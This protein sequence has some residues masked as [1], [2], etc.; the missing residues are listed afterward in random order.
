[1]LRPGPTDDAKVRSSGHPVGSAIG[2]DVRDLITDTAQSSRHARHRLFAATAIITCAIGASILLSA[3]APAYAT[4][5]E[6]LSIE[7][8]SARSARVVVGVVTAVREDAGTPATGA[9]TAVDIAVSDML[10]GAGAGT[11]TVY[12]AGGVEPGGVR[13]FVDGMASFVVGEP[14]AV[15]ADADGWIMGGYQGKVVVRGSSVPGQ[16]ESVAAFSARVRGAAKGGAVGLAVA[17][18]ESAA[19]PQLSPSG[20][21]L[22]TSAS[23]PVITSISPRSA[24]AGT[25]TSIT[26]YGSGFGSGTGSVSF[27][28]RDSQRIGASA[29]SSWTDTR[30]VCQV[31]TASIGGY[32]ASAGS[33]AVLVTTLGGLTSTPATTGAADLAV[34]FG[35]GGARW[36]AKY[37]GAPHTRVTFRVNPSGVALRHTLVT[38][39]AAKWT[40]AGADFA[41]VDGGETS[42]SGFDSGG[43]DGYNDLMWTSS[44]GSGII[45]QAQTT[46]SG[47]TMVDADICFSNAYAWGDGTGG[48]MDVESIAMHEMGHWLFLRDLY[49]G[50][51]NTKV[52]YGMSGYGNV[53]RTL[54]AGDIAG[55]QWIYGA[56]ADT[57]PPVTTSDAQPYYVGLATIHLIANDVG[58]AGVAAT[59]YKVDGGGQQ[60][61]TT[62][63]VLGVGPHTVEF[64]SIDTL[65]N[66]ENPHNTVSFTAYPTSTTLVFRFY[67]VRTGTHF[68]TASP[69]ERDNVI[70]TMGATYRY[71]GLSYTIDTSVAANSVPL[72]RFYNM[73][74]GTH[75]Y[76]ASAAEMNNVVAT[77]SSTYHLDGVAYTVS[78]YNTGATPVYRFYNVRTGTHFYTADE[79]EKAS[80]IANLGATYR[81]EGPAFYI[82]H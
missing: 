1:M 11:A 26:I 14:C 55:I 4:V 44:V 24:S 7:Q 78:A 6:P 68:Y 29:I 81:F 63:S 57:F 66:T 8:M 75:F 43:A 59:Y 77:M 51:D 79:S 70:A 3:A 13:V 53:K 38:A 48:T 42:S 52:M 17:P 72:Y 82:A 31:P 20:E 19:P 56:V 34:T 30:I 5:L 18:Q 65:G 41:F 28:Y 35:N 64:W 60:S 50:G 22:V 10:K 2:V 69:I 47:T 67:N 23:G 49:G 33:G 58:S 37:S 39:G 62:V 45:A 54:T 71:E 73:R 61:G 21:P 9:R 36:A 25:G 12:Y 40:N 46:Y 32:A 76:T 74:T 16:G 27:V 15:F 80:V